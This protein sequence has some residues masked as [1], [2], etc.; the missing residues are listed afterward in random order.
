[1]ARLRYDGQ[2]PRECL[3]YTVLCYLDWLRQKLGTDELPQELNTPPA[4]E[5]LNTEDSVLK[6][7][8]FSGGFVLDITSLPEKGMWAARIR[9][10][11]SERDGKKAQL[12]RFFVTETALRID[13]ED[14]VLGVRI[15][16]IDPVNA[17]Q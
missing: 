16:V 9:E 15:D 7:Y 6:S 12:G 2:T 5:F 8:H 4:R 3:R 11:D 10:P 13:G 17:P 1:M 14:V